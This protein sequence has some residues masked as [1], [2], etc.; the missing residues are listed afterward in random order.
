MPS[1]T[2]ITDDLRSAKTIALLEAHR[3]NM[4]EH[5]PPECVFALDVEGLRQPEIT[6]G[7]AV[8]ATGS[9]GR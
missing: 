4:F 7:F 2:I 9:Y 3:Q 6:L 8:V 1:I 5:S